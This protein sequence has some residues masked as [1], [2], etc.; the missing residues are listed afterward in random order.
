MKYI[1]LQ[2]MKG[3]IKA[4]CQIIKLN[5]LDSNRVGYKD[6]MFNVINSMCHKGNFKSCPC[7]TGHLLQEKMKLRAL[8]FD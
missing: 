4:T 2:M 7:E 1:L 6:D 8:I 3:A 5:T